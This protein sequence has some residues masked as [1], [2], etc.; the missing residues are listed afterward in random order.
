MGA[1][2]TEKRGE[3]PHPAELLQNN[4]SAEP[5]RGDHA[6]GWTANHP[7]ATSSLRLANRSTAPLRTIRCSR[8]AKESNCQQRCLPL[9]GGAE[10][11][12]RRSGR[13]SDRSLR[14]HRDYSL[15][16]PVVQSLTRTRA[17]DPRRRLSNAR[18]ARACGRGGANA[19]RRR[20]TYFFFP[21]PFAFAA[22][23]AGSGGPSYSVFCDMA[24][25]RSDWTRGAARCG[26]RK[27]VA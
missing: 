27:R 26:S 6:S 3:R 14:P 19:P 21:L 12:R 7:V 17:G 11:T 23:G 1:A 20:G 15:G 25:A 22:A 9:A 24:Q 4:C 13:Q 10:R 8:G 16:N 18:R 5:R 2:Y